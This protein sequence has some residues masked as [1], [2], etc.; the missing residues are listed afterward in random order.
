MGIYRFTDPAGVDDPAI[1]AP[2]EFQLLAAH[3]NPFN[4]TT[5]IG[6]SLPVA[7]MVSLSVYDLT[8]REVT[9]LADGVMSAGTHEAVWTAYGM[10]S[11]L[12]VIRLNT[13]EHNLDANVLL[14]R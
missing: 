13:G 12:Y 2:T 9:R 14:I 11:G 7:G 4:S 10:A 8:G 5:T 6:Y 3:P 1:S